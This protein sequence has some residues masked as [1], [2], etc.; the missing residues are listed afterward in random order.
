VSGLNREDSPRR[1]ITTFRAP[2][3]EVGFRERGIDDPHGWI[4]EGGS[5]VAPLEQIPEH[6]PVPMELRSRAV[7]L[8]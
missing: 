3:F 2:G 4:I 6:G 5:L 8:A 7:V 1:L